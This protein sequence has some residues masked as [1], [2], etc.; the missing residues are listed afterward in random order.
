MLVGNIELV[1]NCIG[2]S[3]LVVTLESFRSQS[4]CIHPVIYSVTHGSDPSAI[5]GT[6]VAV[7]IVKSGESLL[8]TDGKTLERGNLLI[9]VEHS[10][11][12]S[13]VGVRPSQTVEVIGV[14][15]G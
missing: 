5:F 4:W 8:R 9:E 7:A 14:G 1:L 2:V 15:L 12:I 11:H 6:M 10:A 13:T 3:P